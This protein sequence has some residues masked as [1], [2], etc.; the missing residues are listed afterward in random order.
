MA[1]RDKIIDRQIGRNAELFA[2]AVGEKQTKEERYPYIRILISIL[3]QARPEW[4]QSPLKDRQMAH[5]VFKMSRGAVPMDETAEIVRLRDMERGL[6]PLPERPE[7]AAA[8]AEL[9]REAVAEVAAAAA[10]AEAAAAGEGVLAESTGE[11]AVDT[12][13]GPGTDAVGE[14]VV[15]PTEGAVSGATAADATEPN[16]EAESPAEPETAS[17]DQVI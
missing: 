15:W 8:A 1:Y 6:I 16:A 7:D 10:E 9:E 11:I 4:N 2:L 5:I 14:A 13:G 17:E 3:E 12:A